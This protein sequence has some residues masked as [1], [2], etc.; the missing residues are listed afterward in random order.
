MNPLYLLAIP[1][2]ALIGFGILAVF[3]VAQAPGTVVKLPFG[4][5]VSSGVP[6]LVMIAIGAGML[7]PP[8]ITV[9]NAKPTITDVR[10]TTDTGQDSGEWNVRCPIAIR[11]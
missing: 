7:Y 8:V 11:L 4:I 3:K 2:I 6:G 10:L 5:E 9:I 1:A